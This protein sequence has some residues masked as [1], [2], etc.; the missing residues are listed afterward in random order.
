MQ[1]SCSAFICYSLHYDT[2]YHF[3]SSAFDLSFSKAF[4]TTKND[5]RVF[6]ESLLQTNDEQSGCISEGVKL[7]T[8]VISGFICLQTKFDCNIIDYVSTLLFMRYL[9]PDLS[10]EMVVNLW[11][12]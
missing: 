1:A 3:S 5:Q 4:F 8:I 2:D 9:L 10:N 7:A 6:I 12:N 11:Q